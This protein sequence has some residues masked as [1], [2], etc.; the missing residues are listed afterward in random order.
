[1]GAMVNVHVYWKCTEG[2]SL[3]PRFFC[4]GAGGEEPGIHQT[5]DS[6]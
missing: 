1:M 3:V 4:V 5:S 6:I 2:D